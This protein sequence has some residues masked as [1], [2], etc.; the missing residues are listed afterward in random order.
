MKKYSIL[1]ISFFTFAF[2]SC[3]NFAMK[4]QREESPLNN[5]GNNTPNKRFKSQELESIQLSI[6]LSNEK[7][8]PKDVYAV[9]RTLND[10]TSDI[11]PYSKYSIFNPLIVNESCLLNLLI[12][13]PY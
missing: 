12:R 4:R 10:L 13:M 9:T 8:I 11:R 5:D 3:N 1:L 2:F 6:L 7:M